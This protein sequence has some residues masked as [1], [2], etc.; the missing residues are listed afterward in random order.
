M[1]MDF[2]TLLMNRRS[3]R[4]F[5]DQ[6][7]PLPLVHDILQDTCLA[8]TASNGQPCRFVI[9]R[10]RELMKRISDESKSNLLA[11]LAGHPDAPLK[12]YEAALRSDAFNVFYNAPCLILIVGPREIPSLEIDCA[13]TAAYLMFSATS[14]GLGTCWVALGAHIRSD[15][16]LRQ[17]GVPEGC[18]IVAPIILGYPK[19]VPQASARHIPDIIR[20]I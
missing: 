19:A 12:R 4:D 7:V 16:M 10:D 15:E 5:Q 13:L 3:I 17:I 9:I 14:R 8:P 18:L 6:E 20:E 1:H 2:K 11:D